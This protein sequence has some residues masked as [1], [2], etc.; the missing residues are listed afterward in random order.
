MLDHRML[1]IPSRAGQ[2]L[3][4]LR[5][6][7]GWGRDSGVPSRVA[8]VGAPV[9]T[10]V[11]VYSAAEAAAINERYR[12]QAARALRERGPDYPARYLDEIALRT[13]DQVDQLLEAIRAEG[14]FSSWVLVESATMD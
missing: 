14:Y 13:A 4:E 7:L 3:V 10:H 6:P 5:L 8:D 11:A 1:G 9:L 2:P 12:E